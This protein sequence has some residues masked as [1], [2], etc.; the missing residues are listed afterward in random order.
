MSDNL[1]PSG[2]RSYDVTPDEL[3]TALRE[4][5][6]RQSARL[7]V[8]AD[9][10]QKVLRRARRIQ[11]R[12]TVVGTAAG[13]MV[14]VAATALAV[15]LPSHDASQSR[16]AFVSAPWNA[17]TTAPILG[18]VVDTDQPSRPVTPPPV[19]LVVAGT[20]HTTDGQ[21]VDLSGIGDVVAA[22]QAGDTWLVVTA[23]ASGGGGL[24]LVGDGTNPQMLLSSVDEVVLAPDGRRVAWRRDSQ[25]FIA[26]VNADRLGVTTSSAVPADVRLLR[27]L[28]PGLLLN[29]VGG[30][31]G[32][33]V[34]WPHRGLYQASWAET[35]T[36]VYGLMPDGRTVVG[37]IRSEANGQRCLALLDAEQGLSPVRTACSALLAVGEIGSVSPDGRWLVVSGDHATPTPYAR[38]RHALVIDLTT[39]FG[40]QPFAMPLEF[41]LNGDVAWIG[42]DT[43][44]YV[45]RQGAVFR[46]TLGNGAS[47]VPTEV[48]R[49]PL[50][51]DWANDRVVVVGGSSQPTAE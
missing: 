2:R 21:V 33:D 28:G 24:W 6:A 47:R 36:A 41:P 39:A 45:S 1:S 27:F 14:V 19:D 13:A 46:V 31:G 5:F 16:S 35:V 9:P 37:Q 22:T 4:M 29:R 17:S 48:E 25:V 38:G 50:P 10:V 18:V 26:S 34:W 8:S 15:Q 11:R 30:A 3:E 51:A 49:V 44:V 7:T 42:M 12:R 40:E 23:D 20:L 32:Y 43:L